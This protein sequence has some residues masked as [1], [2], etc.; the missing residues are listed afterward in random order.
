MRKLFFY[1]GVVL[2]AF[3]GGC[4]ALAAEE[5]NVPVN[6]ITESIKENER[7]QQEAE[8]KQQKQKAIEDQKVM[9]EFLKNDLTTVEPLGIKARP[10]NKNLAI[11][12]AVK[13]YQ[14]SG[15]VEPIIAGNDLILYPYGLS[16]PKVACAFLTTCS[17]ELQENEHIQSK[18]P[19]DSQ[20][21]WFGETVTGTGESLK[22]VVIVKPLVK[23]EISTNLLILTDRRVYNIQL[24]SVTEGTY[25]P[26]IGFFYPQDSESLQKHGDPQDSFNLSVNDEGKGVLSPKDVAQ[27]NFLYKVKGSKEISFYPKQVFDNGRKVYIQM[28]DGIQFTDIPVFFAI[29]PGGV[30]EVVN[31][32]Y[33]DGIYIIDR[34]IKTGVLLLNTN[35]KEEK[36]TITKL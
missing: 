30:R 15:T 26:R 31:Y 14:Q 22:P 5:S 28:Q 10:I 11:T 18:H 6:I 3:N 4:A 2:L 27:W 29:G 19:G 9:E 17:I 36:V 7:L 21:W 20:R 32:R 12:A 25:T 8:A 34:L 23:E 24:Q 16:Q 33:K 13:R 35:G 1:L